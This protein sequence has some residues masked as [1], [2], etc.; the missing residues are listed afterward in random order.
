VKCHIWGITFYGAETWTLREVDQ[1]YLE[2]LELRCWR[3]MEKII[4]TNSAK[5]EEVLRGVE[6]ERNILQTI[7]RG[8]ANW[9]DHILHR[10]Y[11]KHVTDGI[12]EERNDGNTKK[13]T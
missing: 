5:N 8:N 7:N 4:W 6:E 2:G 1:K 3:R 11:I 13:K 10:N 12:I 9:I